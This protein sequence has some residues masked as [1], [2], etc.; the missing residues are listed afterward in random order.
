MLRQSTIFF[1]GPILTMNDERPEVESLA[2]IDGHICGIGSRK[3]VFKLHTSRTRIVDLEGRTLMPGFVDP[4]A[5]IAWS[6]FS[7][8]AE[9]ALAGIPTGAGKLVPSFRSF[10]QPSF[11]QKLACCKRVI[12]EWAR[13][14]CTTVYDASLGAVWGLDELRLFLETAS[15]PATPVRL[16]TA[17]VPTDDLPRLS[18]IRPHQGNDRLCFVGI[19]YWADGEVPDDTFNSGN[20]FTPGS[21]SDRLNY[22]DD[23][24]RIQMQRWHD[25]GWQLTVHADRNPAI[26]QT[27]QVFEAILSETPRADHR[28]R[29]EGCTAVDERQLDKIRQL[30]LSISHRIGHYDSTETNG[31]GGLRDQGLLPIIPIASDLARGLIVSLHGNGAITQVDPLQCVQA[32]VTR[33]V[34]ATGDVL[35]PEERVTVDQALKAITLYPAYQSFLENEVGSLDVGKIADLV[36]LDRNPRAVEPASIAQ[37]RVL[38]TY[39]AGM[40]QEWV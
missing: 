12:R 5:Q 7:T 9:S 31:N 15:E 3:D 8:Y 35:G 20:T 4:H 39:L 6:A 23:E 40:K 2:I 16:R 29:I 18:G 19:K 36:V 25:A 26:E 27:L 32:A 22:D 1:G 28:H 34:R 37:I 33:L 10:Q 14:G 24:L 21:D 17:I 38:E 11:E 13:R 30:G